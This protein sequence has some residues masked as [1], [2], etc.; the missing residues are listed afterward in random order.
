MDI[1][2]F[3]RYEE[4]R[5]KA[6]SLLSEC[7]RLPREDLPHVLRDLHANMVDLCEGAI[8]H[9][10]KM[11]EESE[12]KDYL[13]DLKADYAKLFSGPYTL[14]A[15]PYGSVYLDGERKVMGDS[16]VVVRGIYRR[17]G[18][19]ISEDFHDAPDHIAAELEFMFFL[20]FKEV[21]A[22][23]ASDVGRAIGFLNQQKAFLTD[24]LCAWG[25][26]FT[27]KV[28]GAAATEFYRN[29]ARATRA[30]LEE[31]LDAILD[32]SNVD[33]HHFAEMGIE[34]T[35]PKAERRT[36]AGRVKQVT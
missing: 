19:D 25:P 12:R 9:L 5:G 32:P 23:N 13:A 11:R 1:G 20:I 4:A 8:Q 26:Q 36:G 10:S 7:Y 3:I 33:N 22:L 6:F 18:V 35:Y 34:G 27:E 31:N 15:P 30:F 24:H 16:T 28:E 14:L 17:A 21:E 2:H 29:L